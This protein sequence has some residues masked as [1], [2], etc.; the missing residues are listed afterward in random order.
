MKSKTMGLCLLLS[1]CMGRAEVVIDEPFGYGSGVDLN[2]LGNWV[3]STNAFIVESGELEIAA[4]GGSMVLAGSGAIAM[5]PGD[6]VRITVDYRAHQE[7]GTANQTFWH[8][9]LQD[10]GVPGATGGSHAMLGR[11]HYSE[12]ERGSIRSSPDS[13][14]TDTYVPADTIDDCGYDPRGI[15]SVDD[16]TDPLRMVYT[17]TKSGITNEFS[18]TIEFVNLASNAPLSLAKDVITRADLWSGANVFFCLNAGIPVQSGTGLFL[19]RIAVERLDPVIVAPEWVSALPGDGEAYIS[20]ATVPGAGQYLVYRSTVSG[21]YTDAPVLVYGTSYTDPSAANGTTY[22][23]VVKSTFP[24]GDSTASPEAEVTP[25]P[26]YVGAP[27]FSGDFSAYAE[28]DLADTADWGPITGS[29]SNAFAVIATNSANVADTVATTADFDTAEGN[30]VYLDRL[31]RNGQDDAVEGYIDLVVSA[32]PSAVPEREGCAHFNHQFILDFGLAANTT[33]SL[34]FNKPTMALFSLKTTYEGHLEIYFE[35]QKML[36]FWRYE[37]NW[38]PKHKIL[39]G[40]WAS[41][42]A[43]PLKLY[44]DP[45][46]I[47]WKLR[48]TREAGQYQA[49]AMISNLVNGVVATQDL[50]AYS[51]GHAEGMYDAGLGLFAM[52]HSYNAQ[53]SGIAPNTDYERDSL[54]HATVS[55]VGLAHTTNNLPTVVPPVF[56]DVTAEDRAILL[57]WSD[58]LDA[59]SYTLSMETE[60]G[61]QY[62]VAENYMGTSYRDAPRWNTV[63]NFYTVRANFDPDLVPDFADSAVTSGVPRA[64]VRVVDLNGSRQDLYAG[65]STFFLDQSRVVS[66]TVS[67]LDGTSIPLVAHG[68]VRGSATYMGPTLYGLIQRTHTNGICSGSDKFV[69]NQS[70]VG[71]KFM[72]YGGWN[73]DAPRILAYVLVPDM[74]WE[75]AAP[76][77]INLN[78]SALGIY[79]ETVNWTDGGGKMRAAILNNGQWYVSTPGF[80]L[81]DGEATDTKDVRYGSAANETW[82]Q[83]NIVADTSMTVGAALADNSTLTDITAVGFFCD[84]APY[85]NLRTFEVQTGGNQTS[86]EYWSGEAELGSGNS[87]PGDD[88]DKDGVDNLREYAFGGDPLDG[89]SV[90]TLPAMSLVH[91][92][93]VDYMRYVYVVQR[94]PVAGIAVQCE[95]TED[96][97]FGSYAP[98]AGA[99]VDT[100][101]LDY[102]WDEVTMLVP[103]DKGQYFMHLDIQ[104][105]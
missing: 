3:A 23:Y 58:V 52:G 59:R 89:A 79:I 53:A 33:D 93:G 27:V 81:S 29:G 6:S 15:V 18:A 91:T 74:A 8:A 54:L 97:V 21:S 101:T 96:L 76:D 72:L 99:I 13:Q 47:T 10:S 80:T 69:F 64:M 88:P 48:R 38:N 95:G 57:G 67:Y 50:V 60:G 104:Q 42:A 84:K 44:T 2:G 100:R 98:P 41:D 45:L 30:A 7:N 1:A 77:R 19:D 17:V 26:L 43:L 87:A 9:G 71:Q 68:E 83:L 105:Q 36:R 78:E 34:K 37:A 14:F 75:D 73:A 31:I 102:Y 32:T 70:A 40:Q 49:W 5:M 22:Y 11:V 12:W 51:L 62:V 39:D 103:L 85:L 90:G 86:Y 20:W 63:T 35:D 92:N 55:G 61:E 66:N 16:D 65:G 28:G 82:Y 24:G 56:T 4:D 25:S 94:D 46:R